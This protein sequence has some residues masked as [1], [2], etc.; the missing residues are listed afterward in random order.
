[1]ELGDAGTGSMIGRRCGRGGM[2]EL[3]QEGKGVGA[4][5][6]R[7]RWANAVGPAR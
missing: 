7:A 1:M 3:V 2:T 5:S 4:L 6:T